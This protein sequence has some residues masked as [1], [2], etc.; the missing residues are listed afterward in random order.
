MRPDA[1]FRPL[2]SGRL[3]ALALLP[4]CVLAYLVVVACW[5]WATF[6]HAIA[7]V[8]ILADA[9]LTA[10]QAQILTLVEDPTFFKHIGVSLHRGQGLATITSA[11]ARDV[12]LS[13]AD[14]DGPGG[15]L[16]EFYRAVHACCRQF[17]LG[18]DLMAVVLDAK[19]SKDR[20]LAVYAS[21]V[22]MGRDGLRQLRGLPQAAQSYLGKR[23]SEATDEEFIRLVAMIKAPNAFHPN[24]RPLAFEV[25]VARVRA[26][27]HG[28][29][30]PAGWFDTALEACGRAADTGLGQPH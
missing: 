7:S 13:G 14:M 2:G 27:V 24:R 4:A 28:R 17:D 21:Q 1:A 10:R 30:R 25:R 9:Q 26:L 5:A 11:V 22:Y 15:A 3:R 6:D 12:Y 19:L 23:L 16:Q 8:R 29:C 18:R 20:Q